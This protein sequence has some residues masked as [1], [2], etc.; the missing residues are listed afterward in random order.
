M[1]QCFITVLLFCVSTTKAEIVQNSIVA[2]LTIPLHV[3]V[4]S[5]G[6][7]A[8]G[9]SLCRDSGTC[10]MAMNDT[11]SGVFCGD[12]HATAVETLPCCCAYYTECRATSTAQTCECGG[13]WPFDLHH[14]RLAATEIAFANDTGSR[15]RHRFRPKDDGPMDN[16]MSA[17]TEIFIHLSA[18][19]ALF[20]FAVYVDQWAECFG[21]FRRNQMVTYD[22]AS[23]TRLLYFRQRFR[24]RRRSSQTDGKHDDN[25]PLLLFES[26]TPT[27][28]PAF[29]FDVIS[30]ADSTCQNKEKEDFTISI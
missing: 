27:V 8:A 13:A 23:D 15:F 21:D 29:T 6:S 16:E 12:I 26:P 11:S 20:V 4:P 10:S 19:L 22:K 17:I 7:V 24:K 2:P 30:D 9:C 14:E 3:E 5:G 1:L 25:L 28:K 18:Y